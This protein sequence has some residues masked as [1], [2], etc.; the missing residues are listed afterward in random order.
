MASSASPTADSKPLMVSCSVRA[1]ASSFASSSADILTGSIRT[2]HWSVT[3]SGPAST[4]SALVSSA[5]RA[6]MIVALPCRSASARS[7]AYAANVKASRSARPNIA[8]AAPCDRPDHAFAS[9]IR[10]HASSRPVSAFDTDV[11]PETIA[12]AERRQRVRIP[13]LQSGA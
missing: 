6:V 12:A 5:A 2:T 1:R 9:G 3:L 7:V 13:A 8:D 11:A 4:W 10:R